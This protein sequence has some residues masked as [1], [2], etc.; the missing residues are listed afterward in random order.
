MGADGIAI[1]TAAMI[2]IGCQQYK[3]CNNGR[4]P[5]GIGTQDPELRKRFDIEKSS[6]RLEN[7]FNAV[8]DELRTFARMTGNDD[9]HKLS[10]YDIVTT[11]DDISKYTNI[12]HV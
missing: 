11:N 2:A 1:A 6:K 10:N 9:I 12:K 4:C 7:Y 8:N 3:T 5:V